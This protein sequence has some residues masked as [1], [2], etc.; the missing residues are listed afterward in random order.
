MTDYLSPVDMLKKVDALLECTGLEVIGLQDAI[1][2]LANP[3]PDAFT[4]ISVCMQR[5]FRYHDFCALELGE[6]TTEGGLE[7]VHL[8]VEQK[9]HE[10]LAGAYRLSGMAVDAADPDKSMGIPPAPVI[11]EEFAGIAFSIMHI[12]WAFATRQER[13]QL[14]SRFAQRGAAL[15]SPEKLESLVIAAPVDVLAPLG[16]ISNMLDD[17]AESIPSDG[18]IYHRRL[19]PPIHPAAECHRICRE[20]ELRFLDRGAPKKGEEK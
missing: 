2:L 3:V 11:E 8:L 9:R 5:L 16:E 17:F 12:F 7:V 1:N 18:S 14:L 10:A 19:Y 15:P 13:E 6:L 4:K 20:E